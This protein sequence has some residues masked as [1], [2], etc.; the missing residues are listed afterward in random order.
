MLI[1]IIGNVDVNTFNLFIQDLNYAVC[2]LLCDH[3]NVFNKYL[4]T[5]I[6]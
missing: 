6:E 3:D 2:T 5:Y 4:F 1:S